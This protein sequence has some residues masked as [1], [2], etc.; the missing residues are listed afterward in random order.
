VAGLY[1]MTLRGTAVARQRTD[2]RLDGATVPLLRR[3]SA[4]EPR[5]AREVA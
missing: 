1:A 4:V 5:S 2:F 3:S